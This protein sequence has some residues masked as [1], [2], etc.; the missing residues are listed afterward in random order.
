LADGRELLLEP[1]RLRVRR[2]GG[3]AG[4]YPLIEGESHVVREVLAAG[5][6]GVTPARLLTVAKRALTATDRPASDR[7]AVRAGGLAAL[8]AAIYDNVLPSGGGLGAR[9]TRPTGSLVHALPAEFAV[10]VE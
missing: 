6:A 10:V 9:R 2:D 5:E 7:E 8:A 1:S 3:T 4:D